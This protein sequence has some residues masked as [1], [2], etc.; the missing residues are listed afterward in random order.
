MTEIYYM[1]KIENKFLRNS[2]P[3]DASKYE[4]GY[5]VRR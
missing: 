5:S 2:T 4:F 3:D 1:H